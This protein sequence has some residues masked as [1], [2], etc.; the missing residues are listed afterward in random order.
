MPQL[1]SALRVHRYSF[2]KSAL[3]KQSDEMAARQAVAL[4]WNC[5]ATAPL[6][7]DWRKSICPTKK[8]DSR[9]SP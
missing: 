9:L 7:E 5:P 6:A 2:M 1:L 4:I 8:K 3:I